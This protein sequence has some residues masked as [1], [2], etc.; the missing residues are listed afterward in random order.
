M[1]KPLSLNTFWLRYVDVN[2]L[3]DLA[4]K[5]VEDVTTEKPEAVSRKWDSLEEKSGWGE[6][7]TPVPLLL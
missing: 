6:K 5:A 1:T 3:I 7:A 4:G 2:Y